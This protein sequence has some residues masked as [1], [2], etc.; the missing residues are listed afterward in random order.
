[1]L[2][3]PD[4]KQSRMPYYKW[5][6]KRPRYKGVKW[7]DRTLRTQKSNVWLQEKSVRGSGR[8]H[9]SRLVMRGKS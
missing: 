3:T 8:R 7:R 4:S 1:M 2:K 6:S 9:S 5:L